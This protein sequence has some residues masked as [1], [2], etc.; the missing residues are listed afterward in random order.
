[1]AYSESDIVD[2]LK[3]RRDAIVNELNALTSSSAGG[4]PNSSLTGVDHIGYKR[5]LYEELSMIRQQLASFGGPFEVV[6]EGNT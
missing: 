1:M 2:K 5:A 3:T 6:V 4:K